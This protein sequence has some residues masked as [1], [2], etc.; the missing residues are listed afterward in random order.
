ME[1]DMDTFEFDASAYRRIRLPWLLLIIILSLTAD[2]A[3][4]CIWQSGANPNAQF[5]WN[6]GFA[7]L[8][9]VNL[10]FVKGVALQKYLH[11]KKLRMRSY[12]QLKNGEL[13]HYVLLSRMSHWQVETVKETTFSANGKDEYISA[14]TYYIRHVK[15]ANR[16]P[17]GSIVVEGS[18]ERESLNEGW[19]EYS[20]E[21]GKV[22]KK[23]FKRHLIPAYYKGMDRIFEAL[24]LLK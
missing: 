21:V 10:L 9:I 1:I 11:I 5:Y 16:R 24:N 3:L 17:N 8:C 19:E 14:D 22:F 12:V 7:F 20:S 15:N 13:L 4:F 6:I 23:T 2:A 18:I